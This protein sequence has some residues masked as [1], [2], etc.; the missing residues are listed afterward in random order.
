MRL[1][2]ILLLAL[3]LSACSSKTTKEDVIDTP[4]ETAKPIECLPGCAP[5][6]EDKCV[7]VAN[8]SDGATVERE[9][10]ACAPECC[11]RTASATQG[12][13]DG[14]GV[15]DDG[16]QCPTE[17]EDIDDFQDKDGCPDP[18]NDGDGILDIDDLCAEDAED[19]D[20]F[21]DQDGCPD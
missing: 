20:G 18:D 12:D 4:K 8:V 14:D 9:E 2:I 16:D 5:N 10:I 1:I 15:P 6:V 19:M 3:S 17:P 7:T 13:K 11:D 21:E